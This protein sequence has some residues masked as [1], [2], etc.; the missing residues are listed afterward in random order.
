MNTISDMVAEETSFPTPATNPTIDANVTN[1][2][3]S[4]RPAEKS[5]SK[6]IKHTDNKPKVLNKEGDFYNDTSFLPDTASNFKNV[7]VPSAAGKDIH[8]DVYAAQAA[9]FERFSVVDK[10][11]CTGH[12][13]TGRAKLSAMQ[14]KERESDQKLMKLIPKAL[15]V[16]RQKRKKQEEQISYLLEDF[17]LEV[18]FLQNL[19]DKAAVL[20]RYNG[21]RAHF[22]RQLDVNT[23]DLEDSEIIREIAKLQLK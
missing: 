20:E 11:T 17:T 23:N 4:K 3:S 8:A 9:I 19:K 22:I 18:A 13:M 10:L 16:E 12:S 21:A 5:P 14:T 7:V 6:E 15:F 1:N 2:A